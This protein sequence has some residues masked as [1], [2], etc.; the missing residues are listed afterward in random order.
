MS[1]SRRICLHSGELMCTCLHIQLSIFL[2]FLKD[3]RQGTLMDSL[4][5]FLRYLSD[6]HHSKDLLFEWPDASS[7]LQPG[8]SI[9]SNTPHEP[10]VLPAKLLYICCCWF[11]SPFHVKL[12]RLCKNPKRS[13]LSEMLEPAHLA[14]PTVPVL[15]FPCGN[16]N[17]AF[18][19]NAN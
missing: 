4:F 8:W 18:C 19:I 16:A 11:S 2:S 3:A 17:L 15:I 10:D 12:S 5:V 14:P 7:L 9:F 1:S 13:A 6:H